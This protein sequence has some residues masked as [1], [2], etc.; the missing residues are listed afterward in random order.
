[1]YISMFLK[2]ALL[3]RFFISA[4]VGWSTAPDTVS[5]RCYGPDRV[6]TLTHP[7][8]AKEALSF[9]FQCPGFGECFDFLL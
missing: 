8:A 3:S 9:S 5:S 4:V 7:A 2:A 1:M 6:G